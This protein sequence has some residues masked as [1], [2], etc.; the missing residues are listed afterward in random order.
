MSDV[1]RHI[2]A[3]IA[4]NIDPLFHDK[5]R[6]KL[7]EITLNVI[8]RRKNPYLFRS[9]NILESHNLVQS[10]LDAALSSGEETIFGNFMENIASEV[11]R[12]VHGGQK[13]STVGVDLEFTADK[14]RYMISVKSGP[15]W[16]NSS[17]QQKMKSDFV[18]AQKSLRTS[19]GYRGEIKCVEGCCYGRDDNPDKGTHF[20]LCGQRFWH[21]LSK[22]DDLYLKLIEPLGRVAAEKTAQFER[23]YAQK[24]NLLTQE[25]SRDYC[26]NGVINWDKLVK[27]N[28]G[29]K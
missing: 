24:L 25:F 22:D 29:K 28:S 17:Q 8:L 2:S 11:C 10:V 16:G 9:K 6:K 13:S 20:K 7:D 4:E 21:L 12:F 3:Y 1:L 18:A 15:S 27:Y 19:G 26:V 5:K 14:I 23:Q